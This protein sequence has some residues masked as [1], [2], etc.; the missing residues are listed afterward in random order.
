MSRWTG[1][2]GDDDV[3]GLQGVTDDVSG[4]QG[5]TGDDDVSGRVSLVLMM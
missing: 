5:V 4:L 3:S 2:I 1:V